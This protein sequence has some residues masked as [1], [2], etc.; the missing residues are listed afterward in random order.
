[1]LEFEFVELFWVV[2]L[3]FCDFY[4]QFEEYLGVEQF[5]DVGLG[6]CFDVVELFVFV[7]DDDCFLVVVFDDDGCVYV[8]QVGVF[9]WC[10]VVDYDCD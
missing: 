5:F 8:G 7:V 1:M 6:L 10:D 4:V 3:F 9:V 2:L